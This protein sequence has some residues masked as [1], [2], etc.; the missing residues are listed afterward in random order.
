MPVF[1][2]NARDKS[3][4][5][6]SGEMDL[7]TPQL[8]KAALA[9]QGLFPISVKTKTAQSARM[10]FSSIKLSFKAKPKPKDLANLTRQFEVMFA[11][12]MPMDA[13]LLTLARQAAHP[14]LKEA[15]GHIRNDI[16][17]G[18]RLS[19]AFGRFPNYFSSLYTNMIE[20]G[21]IGGV[22]D[23]TLHEMASILQKEHTIKS[24]V[25][26]ALLYPKIVMGT[27]VAV[28]WLMLAFVF[29]P[30]K[31]F[32]QGHNAELPLPTK[33]VMGLSTLLTTYWYIPVVLGIGG[34]F[35]WKAYKK[36]ARGD[37]FLSGLAFKVPVFGKLNLLV[38][39]S[40]FG[41]LTASLYRSGLP[42]PHALG[43]VAD[44]MDNILYAREVR[45]LKLGLERG[46]TLSGSMAP[47]KYFS[48]MVKETCAVGEQTGKLDVVLDA[49]ATFYDEE[50]DTMLDNLTTLIEPIMLFL[51]FGAVLVLALAVYLPIWNLS[52]VILH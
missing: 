26:S 17:G 11:V 40:R 13:I 19:Q 24:K 12:G 42:L 33:M 28:G 45:Q 49:T 3:G 32:Y 31:A 29:P 1:V 9:S 34:Y 44:A 51:M 30:F 47:T 37:E 23:K 52:G 22:L 39:N 48:P 36:T 25:K 14:A 15:L 18:T 7:E 8:V 20:M 46:E 38:A 21:Q 35:G 50:V 4:S 5:L 43:V 27:L 16:A 2:Y 10:D 41:H 6:L